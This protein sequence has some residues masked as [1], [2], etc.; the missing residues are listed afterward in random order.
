MARINDDRDEGALNEFL[1]LMNDAFL[2]IA[3]KMFREFPRLHRWVSVSDIHQQSV[4]RLVESLKRNKPREPRD[5][6]RM[7]CVMIRRELID[8]TRKYFG[9]LGMGPNHQT[10]MPR[11]ADQPDW[12]PADGGEDVGRLLGWTEFHCRVESLPEKERAVFDL[13]WYQG[14]TQA[15]AARLLGVSERTVINWW[16]KARMSIAKMVDLDALGF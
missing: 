4:L 15:E 11:T 9:P 3:S 13:L 2:K 8:S 7:M 6:V 1:T 16:N 12:D 14:M 5:L 10:V